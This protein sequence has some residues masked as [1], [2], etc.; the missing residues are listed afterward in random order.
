MKVMIHKHKE[1]LAFSIGTMHAQICIRIIINLGNFIHYIQVGASLNC[2]TTNGCSRKEIDDLR[3]ALNIYHKLKNAS[4]TL[5]NLAI[6][7]GLKY[8]PSNADWI[9]EYVLCT[10][11]A[12]NATVSIINDTFG[13]ASCSA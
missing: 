8:G 5:G 4:K 10:G 13:F 1:S 9:K 12:T 7:L 2:T 11:I 6:D 3:A